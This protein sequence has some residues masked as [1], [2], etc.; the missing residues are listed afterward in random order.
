MEPYPNYFEELTL[1]LTLIK[2]FFFEKK[3]QENSDRAVNSLP[4]MD[5]IKTVNNCP[6]QRGVHLIELSYSK[7]TDKMAHREKHKLSVL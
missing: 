7:M 2:K 4:K 5:T 1:E 3:I 6:S